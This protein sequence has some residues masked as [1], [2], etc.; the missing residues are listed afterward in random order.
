MALLE[1]LPKSIS[2]SPQELSRLF[3][4]LHEEIGTDGLTTI[5]HYQVLYPNDNKHSTLQQSHVTS[6][7]KKQ[8][9]IMRSKRYL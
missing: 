4:S 5:E 7:A 2:S 1:F 9:H 6:K 8:Q 3:T